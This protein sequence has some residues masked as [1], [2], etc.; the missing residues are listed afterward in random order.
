MP[1]SL[2]NNYKPT[3]GVICVLAKFGWY[4]AA[5]FI[6]ICRAVCAPDSLRPQELQYLIANLINAI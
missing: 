3:N 2:F 4:C 1:L 6:F 5:Q